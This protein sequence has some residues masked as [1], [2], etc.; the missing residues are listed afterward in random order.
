MIPDALYRSL[1]YMY[2]FP[3]FSIQINCPP[4]KW[5][6]SVPYVHKKETKFYLPEHINI[7]ICTGTGTHL[8]CSTIYYLHINLTVNFINIHY[9]YH[10]TAQCKGT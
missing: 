7:H 8:Y 5:H 6:F 10:W 2:S 3:Q 1:K 9:F 4:E